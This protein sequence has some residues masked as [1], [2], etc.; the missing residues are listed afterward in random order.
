MNSLSLW[1]LLVPL[2]IMTP[3]VACN[4][5]TVK[6]NDA[7]ST[8]S[9]VHSEAASNE[10]RQTITNKLQQLFS[11]N[12]L[13]NKA[14]KVLSI[15]K[16]P[17]D[18]IYSVVLNDNEIIYIDGKGDFMFLGNL[19]NLKTQENLTEK[20]M[21]ELTKM[22]FNQLPFDK[23][24]KETRGNG[25]RKL[26]VFSDPD[27]PFCKKLEQEISGVD[28]VTIYTFLMPLTSLHPNARA[29]A[30]Q[31]WCQPDRAAAWTAWMRDGKEPAKVPQC[32]TPVDEISAFGQ[33]AGFN[34]T[35]TLIFPN[36]EVESGLIPAEQLNAV[37]DQKQ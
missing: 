31:I 28:N 1:R 5:T 2:F 7:N 18:N 30:E 16:T 20:Q 32:K 15:N 33:K 29:K 37:L 14:L 13:P 4:P 17:L 12:G 24:I 11:K 25:K 21:K 3:L 23:A 10:V 36:G 9:E 19:I 8:F 6:N 34:G 35:P 22:D 27:C 26:A